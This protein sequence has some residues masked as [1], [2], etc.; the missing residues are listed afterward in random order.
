VV[1]GSV[2]IRQRDGTS[3]HGFEDTEELATA[4][5][6]KA[7]RTIKN[8]RFLN[9]VFQQGIARY[10]LKEL[11]EAK[12]R[13]RPASDTSDTRVI[14]YLYSSHSYKFQITRKTAKRVFYI[15]QPLPIEEPEYYGVT[16]LRSSEDVGYVDRLKLEA[17]GGVYNGG[18]HWSAEDYHLYLSIDHMRR[19][20][21]DYRQSMPDLATLKAEMAAA[22]PDR[23]GS[24]EAFVT[25]RSRY[26]EARR[27][28]AHHSK[29]AGAEP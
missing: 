9:V 21:P 1:L 26:V 11:N 24:N 18:R 10:V 12:Q 25:A 29:R 16:I 2:A 13:Q 8:Q 4:E 6:I 27:S 3:V 19:A 5:A 20:R 22:H 23:G 17:E 28:M 15:R 14:E 7:V